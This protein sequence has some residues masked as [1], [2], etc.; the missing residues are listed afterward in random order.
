MRDEVN[1]ALEAAR[2]AKAIGKPLEASVTIR[3][4]SVVAD[5]LEGCNM[6]L[7]ELASLCIVSKLKLV[8]DDTLGE[9]DESFNGFAVDIERAS[10]EK[11]ERCWIYSDSI[12]AAPKH[13]TL[14]SRCAAVVG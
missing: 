3:A 5:F 13:P 1:K 8:R 11:C 14:C 9:A 4:N 12:G 7:E 2:N 10:G 6:S